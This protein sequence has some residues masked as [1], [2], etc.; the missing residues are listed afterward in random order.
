M[1]DKFIAGQ[2]VNLCLQMWKIPHSFFSS[3]LPHFKL[4][5]LFFFVRNRNT[6][7][8]SSIII[9]IRK[10]T[11]IKKVFD[12]L[13]WSIRKWTKIFTQQPF[14][15]HKIELFDAIDWK[16]NKLLHYKNFTNFLLSSLFIHEMKR[17]QL[18]TSRECIWQDF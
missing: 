17:T 13:N 7:F 5:L 9:F 3:L 14:M 16:K 1:D 11:I 10:W 18:Y 8:P 6:F 2:F 15:E 12:K 4:L